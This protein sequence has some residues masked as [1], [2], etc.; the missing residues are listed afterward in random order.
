MA[1][2]FTDVTV[3]NYND[4]APS[5]DASAVPSNR[6]T[7]AGVKTEIGDPLKTAIESLN[8]NIG[9]AADKLVGGGGVT[10]SGAPYTV[11]ATDQGKLVNI[12]SAGTLTTATAATVGAPFVHPVRNASSGTLTIDGAGS[13]TI[14]GE[15][16]IT[17]PAGAGV[18]LFT[19][20]TN[21]FTAGR[22]NIQGAS[23]FVQA[24]PR[25]YLAGLGLSNGTD[26]DHDI[27]IAVGECRDAA[28]SFDFTISSTHTKRID[29]SWASGTGNGGLAS[30]VSLSA[31]TT[32]HMFLVDDGSNGIEAG[33]D[34]SLTATN[35]LSDSGGTKYRRIGSVVT[36]GSANILGFVQ[37]GDHFQFTA[38][39]QDHS[40]TP[41]ST[42]AELK[43][44][45]VPTGLR[46]LADLLATL[47][48]TSG[49]VN[50]LFSDPSTSDEAGATQTSS[51]RD[52]QISSASGL[53]SGQFLIRTNTSSQIRSRSGS[54]SATVTLTTRGWYDTRGR[55]A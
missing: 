19:D 9:A 10:S 26:S 44:L 16:T 21:W 42:S 20:G 39:E 45:T 17:L 7:W 48:S 25:G 38:L 22:G 43:A 23:S 49:E 6:I 51:L 53:A 13:E 32:Y 27:D 28:D 29:A 1:D 50:I 46:V 15:T 54:T 8:T 30:A 55:D 4:D 37:D 40:Y 12:T 35:L 11:Q 34:T 18:I 24:L 5:D 36:D 31:D 3:L 14:D 33:F 41:G 52:A 2:P 47:E